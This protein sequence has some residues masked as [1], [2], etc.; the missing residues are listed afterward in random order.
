MRGDPSTFD[1]SIFD[2]GE[3]E[4]ES[5]LVRRVRLAQ[6]T[7]DA[8]EGAPFRLGT[9]DCARLAAT[10]LRRMGYPVRLPP[11]GSY[12]T[13]RGALRKLSERGFRNMVEAIGGMGFER[14]A[15]ARA[16]PADL[17]AI[18][19][20]GELGGVF[21]VMSNGRAFGFHEDAPGAAVIQPI[22]YVAAW[23]V[24]VKG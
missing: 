8:W 9:R 11:A 19:S 3:T 10:H 21:V 23:R 22:E 17:I 14:I 6:A 4:I 20:E 7:L 18:P 1:P 13:A 16:L 12:A 24:P 5:D 2:P 15:P